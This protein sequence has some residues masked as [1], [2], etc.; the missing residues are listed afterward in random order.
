MVEDNKLNDSTES[1]DRIDLIEK[2]KDILVDTSTRWI[3][4]KQMKVFCFDME[5][6]DIKME[7]KFG[8]EVMNGDWRYVLT[9]PHTVYVEKP[10]SMFPQE[11][12]T[13]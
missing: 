9:L 3:N 4:G 13:A 1:Q 10:Y 8:F 2:F 11:G 5:H 7:A 12:E 6:I